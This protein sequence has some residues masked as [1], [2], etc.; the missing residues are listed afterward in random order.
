[1]LKLI[2]IP[3]IVILIYAFKTSCQQDSFEDIVYL[4]NENTVVG[5]IIENIPEK[6]IKIETRGGS[7]Y[8]FSSEEV[9][10]VKQGKTQT[11]TFQ[12]SP[13][14]P[15]INQESKPIQQKPPI[16]DRKKSQPE[17]IPKINPQQTSQK[18]FS[19]AE[20]HLGRLS[21]KKKE[22][23]IIDGVGTL[24]IGTTLLIWGAIIADKDYESADIIGG[25]IMGLGAVIDGVGIWRLSSKSRA[26]EEYENV[27]SISNINQRESSGRAALNALADDAHSARMYRGFGS[28][29]ASIGMFIARP[30]KTLKIEGWKTVYEDS[31]VNDYFGITFGALAIYNFTFPDSEEKALER[32]EQESGNRFKPRFGLKY[33]PINGMQFCMQYIF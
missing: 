6:Y 17:I 25:A 26:E 4:K 9:S 11:K 12:Q 18:D 21:A 13:Q 30:Y 24:A 19:L 14:A 22:L 27:K 5:K 10:R 16:L 29:A 15:V 31:P 7:V 8:T 1:M 32:Y 23:R 33:H 28:L 3:F 2:F 20:V